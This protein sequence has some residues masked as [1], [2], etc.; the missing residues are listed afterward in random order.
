MGREERRCREGRVYRCRE[1]EHV[2]ESRA[3]G[4]RLNSLARICAVRTACKCTFRIF[5][6]VQFPNG[7]TKVAE[8]RS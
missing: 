6:A 2:P 7:K 5:V 1:R 8:E 4:E 3:R